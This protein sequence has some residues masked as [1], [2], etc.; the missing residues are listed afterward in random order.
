MFFPERQRAPDDHLFYDPTRQQAPD[1]TLVYFPGQQEGTRDPMGAMGAMGAAEGMEPEAI[2][3]V[4]R[5][6]LVGLGRVAGQFYETMRMS[7]VPAG[8]AEDLVRTWLQLHLL[9]LYFPQSPQSIEQSSAG[10]SQSAQSVQSVDGSADGMV[11]TIPFLSP[12]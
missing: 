4:Y 2:E 7:G 9:R 3:A 11:G 5:A 8:C 10:A 1:D 6:I 12:S